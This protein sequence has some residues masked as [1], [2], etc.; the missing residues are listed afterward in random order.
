M[1]LQSYSK[2]KTIQKKA[3]FFI[4]EMQRNL[5]KVTAKIRLSEAKEKFIHFCEREDF[6]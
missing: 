5:F 1:C 3:L 6:I 2:L 4:V